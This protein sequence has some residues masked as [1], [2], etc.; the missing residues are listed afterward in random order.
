MTGLWSLIVLLIGAINANRVPW[1]EWLPGARVAPLR[2]VMRADEF[3]PGSAYRLLLSLADLPEARDLREV[4]GWLQKLSKHRW[5][6]TPPMVPVKG[7]PWDA[8]TCARMREVLQD[9][10]RELELARFVAAMS[11][12]RVPTYLDP[13]AP[14][15]EAPGLV[16]GLRHALILSAYQKEGEGDYAGAFAELTTF[17]RLASLLTRGGSTI[18]QMSSH[19]IAS[20]AVLDICEIA[21]R[22]HVPPDVLRGVSRELLEI[23]EMQDSP[24]EAI[25]NGLPYLLSQCDAYLNPE[26]AVES[27]GRGGAWVH[28]VERLAFTFLAGGTPADTRRNVTAFTGRIADLGEAPYRRGTAREL[29]ALTGLLDLKAFSLT[30]FGPH[31]PYAPSMAI[32]HALGIPQSTPYAGPFM[33]VSYDQPNWQTSRPYLLYRD[34]YGLALVAGHMRSFARLVRSH[35]EHQALLRGTAL[36]LALKAY[37]SDHRRPPSR[38]AELVPRYVEALPQ[39][40]FCGRQFRYIVGRTPRHWGNVTWGIYSIASDFRDDGGKATAVGSVYHRPPV[41]LKHRKNPDIVWIPKP[42]P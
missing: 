16:R 20:I 10:E 13:F 41:S 22:N 1:V 33:K 7:S 31:D 12:A 3:G 19:P 36:F 11:T 17:L 40:P 37:E 8:R 35:A 42:F 38:L 2:P 21:S 28:C 9:A 29:A 6:A 5:P 18:H 26:H 23:C 32:R 15:D 14:L 4:D 30:F 39:D 25:R 27:M 34:P 24:S